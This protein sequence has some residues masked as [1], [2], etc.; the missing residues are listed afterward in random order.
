MHE[1]EK[2]IVNVFSAFNK[3]LQLSY[4]RNVYVVQEQNVLALNLLHASTHF[5]GCNK[6]FC[7]LPWK[8][9]L[10]FLPPWFLEMLLILMRKITAL[11]NFFSSPCA[12]G[13]AFVGPGAAKSR[14]CPGGVT[15]V[16][17]PV[18]TLESIPRKVRFWKCSRPGAW[19]NLVYKK[20][21]CP[22]QGAGTGWSLRP[23]PT[24]TF[25][26]FHNK[27][28]LFPSLDLHTPVM[29]YKKRN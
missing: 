19:G 8:V 11:I 26:R 25:P 29:T 23:L 10:L 18:N 3:F 4:S 22:W 21:P 27:L 20:C 9:V 16:A 13:V 15:H 17:A 1:Q 2:K 12:Y 14:A 7:N 5:W 24:H 28:M 6:C